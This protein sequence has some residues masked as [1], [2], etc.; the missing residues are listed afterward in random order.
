MPSEL[1]G[2]PRWGRR[3]DAPRARRGR[4][5][6]ASA[7]GGAV[8]IELAQRPQHR[9]TAGRTTVCFSSRSREL[10]PRLGGVDEVRRDRHV[11]PEPT[12]VDIGI[13]QAAHQRLRRCDRE[14]ARA[15]RASLGHPVIATGAC[16]PA[17][18]ATPADASASVTKATTGRASLRPG[19]HP[20]RHRCDV[21]HV[22]EHRSSVATI[23]T[24]CRSSSVTSALKLL[25]SERSRRS[26]ANRG[27][28][29]RRGGRRAYGTRGSRTAAAARRGPA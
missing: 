2:W 24:R 23:C 19:S 12:Q 1:R 21:E 20:P 16:S 15:H 10:V 13:E 28:A 5:A 8:E 26:P 25:T 6:A 22:D 7:G 18:Q 9:P 4:P 17:N 27:R 3:C 29:P 14:R 11:E